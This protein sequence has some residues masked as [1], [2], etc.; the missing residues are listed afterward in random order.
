MRRLDGTLVTG[1]LSR[2]VKHGEIQ[3]QCALSTWSCCSAILHG[4][5]LPCQLARRE[6]EEKV[7]CTYYGKHGVQAKQKHFMAG[8]SAFIIIIIIDNVLI[9]A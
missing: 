4:F 6:R 9:F 1:G 2:L 5:S 7:L 3:G 8:I